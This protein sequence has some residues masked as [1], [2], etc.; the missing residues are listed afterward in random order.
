MAKEKWKSVGANAYIMRVTS[1]GYTVPFRDL[2]P[3][4][5]MK[6]NKSA[7][8]NISFVKTEVA[9]LLKKGCIL[10]VRDQ[11]YVVNPLT[12]AYGKTGKPRLVLDCRHIYQYLIQFKFKYEDV[13][14][15][16]VMFDVGSFLFSFDLKGA[17]HH[18][19]ILP[20]YRKYLGFSVSD[21]SITKY[22]VFCVLPFGLATAGYIFSKVLRVLVKYWRGQGH[23]VIMYLDDGIGGNKKNMRKQLF[24]AVT[25]E[26]A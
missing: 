4:K 17:Y 18:I 7:R 9:N 20:E 14:T 25:L 8:D 13:H 10:E 24:L 22:Y 16:K 26:R 21:G 2:P 19:E 3:S 12:V 6:N 15:A 23:K 5:V 1:E 11:P